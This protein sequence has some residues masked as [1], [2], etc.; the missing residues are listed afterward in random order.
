[1][2]EIREKGAEAVRR[3]ADDQARMPQLSWFDNVEP[4][5]NSDVAIKVSING[6]LIRI[7]REDGRVGD[8]RYG[9]NWS[10]FDNL[11]VNLALTAD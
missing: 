2:G 4:G 11:V 8:E 9:L 10:E 5:F 3:H 1:M 7:T 6:R